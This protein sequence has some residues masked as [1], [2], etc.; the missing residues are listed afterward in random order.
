MLTS[1][2]RTVQ[3]LSAS[4]AVSSLMATTV[5]AQTLQA[6]PERMRPAF[7]QIILSERHVAGQAAIDR[8]GAKLPDV[9]NW[10]GK[11]ADQLRKQLLSDHNVRIDSNGRMFVV[12]EMQAPLAGTTYET[13]Q[14]LMDGQLVSTDQ[15]FKLHSRPGAPRTIYLDFDGATITGTAWNRASNISTITAKRYDFDGDTSSFSLTE[16]KRIQYIWQRVA[17]DYS[18]FDV[19][20]TTEPPPADRLTRSDSSDQTFGTTVVITDNRGVYNCSCGGIAYVGVFN[21]TSTYYKPALVFYNMLANGSEKAVAE[22]ISHEAGHNIGLSHDGSPAGEYYGGQGSSLVTGWAPIMGVGYDKPL[23]QFSRGEYANANNTEDDF[24][25][26]QGYGLPL[27]ADDFGNSTSSAA[28][29]PGSGSS[30][31]GVI[32]RAGDI[33]VFSFTAS[34]GSFTASASPANRSANAD[35]VLK[36]FNAAGQQLASSNPLNALNA[37]LSYQ[38]PAAGTYYIQ[39]SATGQGNPATDGY[40]AYGSV[41]NYR[42]AATYQA[43]GTAPRAV[44]TASTTSGV[45]PAAITFDGSQSTDA[46]GTVEFYY[47]NFGDGTTDDSG[48]MRNPTKTYSTPGTYTARLTVVDNNGYSAT[49][50]KTITI[51]AAARVKSVK[52]RSVSLALA[53]ARS[54]KGR[55]KS[56]IIVVDDLNQVRRGAVVT[57]NWTGVVSASARKRSSRVGKALFTSPATATTGCYTFTITSISLPGYAVDTSSLPSKQVCR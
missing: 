15:T 49:T 46:D 34:A 3:L 11:S 28:T 35:L 5:D 1:L 20:V 27:R 18:V 39:V 43:G 57:A 6:L 48:T 4:L 53:V 16:L 50:S 41:G 31:D 14:A 22:A 33:D 30:V 24:A 12:E 44:M 36:L 19:D 32:G 7:P 38:I 47:W 21:S 9:A 37:S 52:V 2:K 54:G 23:V 25:V 29:F 17:E 8:L 56:T 42:V 45:A 10:Y 40:S 13:Q 51:A 55:V 26:A